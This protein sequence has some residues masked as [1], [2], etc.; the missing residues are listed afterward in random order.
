MGNLWSPIAAVTSRWQDRANVQIVVAISAASIVPDRPR[1]LVQIYKSNHSH[2]MIY[3]SGVFTLNF[4]RQD[5]MDLI[6]SFGLVSGRD[7]D[8]LI[9]VPWE[10]GDTGT[11]LLQDCWGYLD[12]RVVNAMDGGDLTCFLADVVSGDIL[13]EGSP[14]WLRDARRGLPA[15]VIDEWDQK[16][17]REIE[18][19]RPL[20]GQFDPTPWPTPWTNLDRNQRIDRD[21]TK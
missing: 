17:V 7:K 6:K 15:E 4:L 2:A 13:S 11:P 9:D 14:L 3:H 10:S 5:Q 19:S 16:N 8:K 21:I 12:C 18:L 1:V 20:M